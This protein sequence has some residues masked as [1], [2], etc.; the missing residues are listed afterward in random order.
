MKPMFAAAFAALVVA[1]APECTFAAEGAQ[2][3]VVD[4]FR[5]PDGG[6]DYVSVDSAAQRVFIARKYGVMAIDLKDRKVIPELIK[7]NDVSAV[8]IIPGT[9]LLLTTNWGGHT[10]TLL[11]RRTGK[12]KAEIVTGKQPD[13]AVFDPSSRRAFVMNGESKDITVVDVAKAVAIATIPLGGKPEAGAADGKG[14]IYVNIEDTAQ[15]AVIDTARLKVLTKYSIPECEE[16][17]G[18]A[19]DAV[20][21]VLISACHNGIARLVDAATGK[22]R[23]WFKVGAEADGAIFDSARRL[24]YIPCDDGTMTI[25]HLDERAQTRPVAVVKTAR[26]ARTA[27]LDPQTGRLYL[28]YADFTTDS[29]GEDVQTPGTFAVLVV[30]AQ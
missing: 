25:V 11:D 18:I 9:D 7:G 5:G 19:Y 10:A 30:A 27:A 1:C 29:A 21:G 16:P 20:T 6:Y 4:T 3:K 14:R 17:T 12:A 26:G 24:A 28:P 13:A 2:Y 8:L 15:I 23:G 22:D